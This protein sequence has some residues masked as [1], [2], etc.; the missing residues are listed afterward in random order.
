VTDAGRP[1]PARISAAGIIAPVNYLAK[2]LVVRNRCFR[3]WSPALWLPL[4]C[5]LAALA[6]TRGDI[7]IDYSRITPLAIGGP[8]A[9]WAA[10]AG[11]ITPSAAPA[12]PA[13][14]PT[15]VPA[16]PP[17]TMVFTVTPRPTQN[18]AFPPTPD[19]TR[20][21]ILDRSV[22]GNYTVQRGDT[23]GQISQRYGVSAA[24]LAQANGMKVTDTLMA[25]RNLVVPLP[26]VRNT[27]PD[28]KLLPDSEFVYGPGTVG[29]N[30]AGFIQS[31]HSYLSDY[32][33]EVAGMYLDGT[34]DRATLTGTEIVQ[35]V[36]ERY[37]VSP[38]VLLAVLDYQSGWVTSRRPSD[39][40]L[41]FPI[42]RVEVGREGLL[43]QLSWAANQLNAGYYGWR[44][45]SL[46]SFTFD[47][48]SLRLI[49]RG[50]NAG[51]VGVQNFFAQVDSVAD[52]TKAVSATGFSRSY[53]VLF[54]NPF[55]W[56]VEPLVPADL[57]QPPM[58]LP[59]ESGRTWAFTGGP[60]AGWDSGSAWAAI[61]FAPADIAGC[62]TSD[63]WVVASAPGVIVQS[64]YGAVLEDLD[65]D[66][67][68][69]TGWVILYLHVASRDRVSVGAV[70]KAGDRLGH[71]SC[72]GGVANATHVHLARRYNGE[73]ISAD[74]AVPFVLDGWVSAGLGKEYDGDLV[75]G[76]VT[77]E[78]YDGHTASNEISR[79]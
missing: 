20:P 78:A 70:V 59:F 54:G 46:A 69:G 73:W 60:H 5:L 62:E 74:G 41:V 48:G 77:I 50:L 72:E 17:V 37:S 24:Q 71:P 31:Q 35:L 18:V 15:L 13:P 61:D 9:T 33:E 2:A 25:G 29:F 53:R 56:G 76:D 26:D 6:C 67:Y 66:G 64:Q 7:P 1:R 38:K 40:T 42:G 57:V 36:A 28:N 14:T 11:G 34:M 43:R 52:W 44:V 3:G 58:Q 79:P 30:L 16:T 4:A 12:T 21:S 10:R 65:G 8:T 39:N 68:E 47:D 19:A 63:E 22:V 51:T 49:A 45:G 32:T 75:K 23:L 27:G 55:I